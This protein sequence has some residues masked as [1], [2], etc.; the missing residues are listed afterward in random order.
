MPKGYELCARSASCRRRRTIASLCLV[1]WQPTELVREIESLITQKTHF[2]EELLDTLYNN[3][4][5]ES[6]TRSAGK[7]GEREKDPERDDA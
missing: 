4:I 6:Q 3:Y 2:G 7:C 5:A 1:R